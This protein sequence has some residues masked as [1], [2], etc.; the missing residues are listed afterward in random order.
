[1]GRNTLC[2]LTVFV[3]AL[4]FIMVNSLIASDVPET[5][6]MDS[7][8]YEKHRKGS[9]TFPHKKH[10]EYEGISCTDC[11]HVYEDGKNAWKEGDP[12]Q[13]CEACHS[14]T[15]RAPRDMDKAERI[16]QYHQDAI[17]E[18]C[19]GCHKKMVDRSTE[20]GKALARCSGCH[21]CD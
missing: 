15:G 3:A 8:L 14:K 10:A 19:R 6:T 11:H 17:H 7:K 20:K 12:V 9:V 5:I 21:Q 1:M 4:L 2:T 13:N 18:N 16:K